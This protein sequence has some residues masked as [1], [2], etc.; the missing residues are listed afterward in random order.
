MATPKPT[1]H[2]LTA[3]GDRLD[4]ALSWLRG[5]AETLQLLSRDAQVMAA[6]G[7]LIC[8][9]ADR[10][11]DAALQSAMGD[12]RAVALAVSLLEVVFG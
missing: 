2:V 1:H 5:N 9:D 12:K 11:E 6:V 10:I 4:V 7:L 8:D 3:T